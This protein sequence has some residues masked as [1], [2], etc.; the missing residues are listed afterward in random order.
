MAIPTRAHWQ[1]LSP[2]LDQAFS[3]PEPER[4]EWLAALHERDPALAARL[5]TPL[6]EHK[7]LAEEE[8]LERSPLPRES[9]LTGSTIGAYTLL[10]PLGQGGMSTV[11]LAERND[12]RFQARV[13]V[14]FLNIALLGRVGQERFKREGNILG[15]LTINR[16]TTLFLKR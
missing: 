16:G 12:G 9:L 14:K 6:D 15:R 8:F 11:W 13:A 10:Q 1:E 4:A 2:Y 7:A 3:I 5:Q